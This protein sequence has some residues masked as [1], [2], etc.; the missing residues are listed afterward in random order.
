MSQPTT[1]TLQA[2]ANDL[3]QKFEEEIRDYS[4]GLWNY[5]RYLTGSPWDGED[6]YQETM[7]KVLGGLY[8]RWHP[9]NLKSYVFRIATNTWIDLCRKEKR[10]LGVLSEESDAFEEFSDSLELEEAL[11]QL[12]ELFTPRQT[13]VFLLLEVFR[14]Q[15]DEIASIVKTTPGAVY[16]SVRRMRHKIQTTKHQSIKSNYNA[17]P[18]RSKIIQAYLKAFNHG[19]LEGMLSLISDQAH[20]EASLGFLEVNKD[21]IR[22]GSLAFGLPGHHA[23]QCEL[24]GKHVIVVLAESDQSQLVH[25]IQYQEVENNK[26]VY[27]RSFFFRKEFI[28]AAS[29]ELG[30]KPQLNK[31]PLNWEEK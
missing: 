23:I 24:W 28:V 7:L 8:T 31:P 19:D 15:A 10:T 6:L 22:N 9:T 16:A 1:H 11:Q 18:Q 20:Y 4:E 13:A 12:D 26:I 27:H 2:Q 17:S 21:E 25:D 5:C 30:Y 3:R 14:F 29:K